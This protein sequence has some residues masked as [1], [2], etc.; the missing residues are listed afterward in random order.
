MTYR[1]YFG[2]FEKYQEAEAKR[3]LEYNKYELEHWSERF[4]FYFVRCNLPMSEIEAKKKKTEKTVR[5]LEDLLA[6]E[7]RI[8]NPLYLYK[9]Q[10]LADK[11]CSLYSEADRII[12]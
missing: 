6:A 8:K 10:K 1:E 12:K 2:T 4:S 5:M 7:G 9:W 11:E 3:A